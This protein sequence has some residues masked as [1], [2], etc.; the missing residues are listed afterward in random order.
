MSRIIG[1]TGYEAAGEGVFKQVIVELTGYE[2]ASLSDVLREELRKQG[3]KVIRKNLLELGNE[4]RKK[5][6]R[7]ILARMVADK[8]TP[9][10]VI[11]SIKNP[12][13]V[14]ELR[15]IYGKKFVLV[16]ITASPKIRFERIRERNRENDPKTWKEFIELGNLH[17]GEKGDFSQVVNKCEEITDYVIINDGSLEELRTK[18]KALIDYLR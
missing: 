10:A 9:P 18:A 13:E 6:G 2:S 12:E 16:T 4:L 15:R 17:S 5:H 7:G 8:I 11:D 14:N 3:K 1:L